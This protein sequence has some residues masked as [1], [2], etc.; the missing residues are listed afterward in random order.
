M[1]GGRHNRMG[2]LPFPALVAL[3]LAVLAALIV[4]SLL[5]GASGLPLSA[6]AD[7]VSGDTGSAAYRIFVY[8]RLPRTLAAIL[9]GAA[10]SAAGVTTQ[11][12]LNNAMA[13]PSIIGV[14]AG[15]NLATLL[16]M[17]LLPHAVRLLPAA[18]FLGALL[19]SVLVYAIAAVAGAS[20]STLLLAGIAVT[21][22]IGAVSSALRVFFPDIVTAASTFA[23]GGLNGVQLDQVLNAG[24]YI[25][26]GLAVVLLLACD[27]NV[28][29]L[30][31]EVAHSLGLRVR[32][33]RFILLMAAS[34][35]AGAA[36]SFAGLIGFVGLIVPHIA[37]Y[38][39]QADN[40]RL[41][42]ASVL[43]GAPLMLLCDILARVVFAPFELPVG[44]LLSCVGGPYFIY[45][46][47]R[48]RR[49]GRT[50]D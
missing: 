41:L 15:A 30:G 32:A 19:C 4:L 44:I 20:R 37:R 22:I 6:L 31:E 17:A 8:V 5:V 34:L 27:M 7:V 42:L 35:L 29:M 18:A 24:K 33:S 13:G 48:R 11:A 46:I 39:V 36:V 3:L 2:R 45:L 28:L 1:S 43:I 12:V 10:L 40:R 47:L 49:G 16:C 21:N 38:F 50:H 26:V 23:V 9:A 25:A 14:N